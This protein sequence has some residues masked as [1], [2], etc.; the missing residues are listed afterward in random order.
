MLLAAPPNQM[1]ETNFSFNSKS[2][3]FAT[4]NNL[5]IYGLQY[6]GVPFLKDKYVSS[7]TVAI[8]GVITDVLFVKI[9]SHR[10]D[11]LGNR[12]LLFTDIRI[13][14]KILAVI[15]IGIMVNNTLLN[16]ICNHVC[17]KD[18]EYTVIPLKIQTILIQ[19]S[20]SIFSTAMY[21]NYL[22]FHWAYI[23]SIDPL[24]DILVLSWFTISMLVFTRCNNNKSDKL[25]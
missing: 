23:K 13:L 24:T 19:I 4:A 22:K 14:Y 16:F 11:T 12:L 7:A 9:F 25:V 18:D 15:G 10:E 17:S 20:V 2:T 6:M 1:N 8:L 21:L 5:L 3:A